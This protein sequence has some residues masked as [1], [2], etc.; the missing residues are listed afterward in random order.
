MRNNLIALALFFAACGKSSVERPKL[1]EAGLPAPELKLV[2]LINAPAPELGGWR[3]LGGKAAVLEFWATWCEPC[4]DNIPRMNQL[5]E[6]FRDKAVVF[7]SIT[8]E[9]EAEVRAFM[10]T[11][12]MSGWVA[13]EAGAEPFKAF[14]VYSRPYTVLVA[15]DGRVFS[16]TSSADL[17]AEGVED[18]LAGRRRAAEDAARPPDRGLS[19]GTGSPALAEFFIAPDSSG[20]AGA[21]CGNDFM[22]AKALT[23]RSAFD[24]MLGPSDVVDLGPGVK[25]IFDSRYDIRVS[26]P[27]GAADGKK[28][29]FVKGIESALGLKVKQELREAEVYV[30]KAAPGGPL[31]KRMKDLEDV[32]F[33]GVS[34][35]APGSS[36]DVLAYR[37][38]E[39]LGC[40]VL[41]ETK[42]DGP[43]QYKFTFETG[44]ARLI[45]SQL[46]SRLG[47]RLERLKRKIK[48]LTV[49]K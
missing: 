42:A 10:Q 29:I 49:N 22:Y 8:D 11:H 13:P 34:L 3:D 4:V 23:L 1:A 28:G 41:N 38:G 25:D 40:P 7:I 6:Q 47:L 44:D 21:S 5:A 2:K 9:S 46:Q 33:D 20:A 27:P 35:D 31:A 48:V 19:D 32:K 15:P 43:F 14:R 36:F 12:P 17:T 16:S 18:L 37:L 24:L 30:L 39:R 45:S 26:A